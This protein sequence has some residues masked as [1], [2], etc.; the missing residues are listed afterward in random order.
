MRPFILF[1]LIFFNSGGPA[2]Y[3][4]SSGVVVDL[5]LQLITAREIVSHTQR[6]HALNRVC[7]LLYILVLPIDVGLVLSCLLI[8]VGGGGGWGE[9][10]EGFGVV[11]GPR[12]LW[13]DLCNMLSLILLCEFTTEYTG[14]S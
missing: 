2:E 10:G 8:G 12:V 13:F 7:L 3:L 14:P 6:P 4:V 1:Y 11:R 9:G 5:F